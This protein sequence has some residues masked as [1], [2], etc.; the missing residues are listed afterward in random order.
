EDQDLTTKATT[1]IPP[2]GDTATS[3]LDAAAAAAPQQRVPSNNPGSRRRTSGKHFN[4]GRLVHRSE[5]EIRAHTSYLV[6]AVLPR[7]WT[8]EDEEKAATQWPVHPSSS[9]SA[10]FPLGK[11]GGKKNNKNKGQKSSIAESAEVQKKDAESSGV[12]GV[13]KEPL[14]DDDGDGGVVVV[15]LDRPEAGRMKVEALETNPL[16]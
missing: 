13:K 16:S 15:E 12:V 8:A 7:Q 5:P 10:S 9:S 14:D 1:T 2:V 11:K 3:D 4:E 6:F